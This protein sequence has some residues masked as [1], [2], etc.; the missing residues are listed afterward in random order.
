MRFV[1]PELTRLPLPGGEW[2][3]VK[4]RLTAGE[5]REMVRRYTFTKD[6]DTLHID[7]LLVGRA[8]VLAYL[9][10]WSLVGLD[11]QPL[12]IRGESLD[13]VSAA[14]DQLEPAD[15]E[16]LKDAILAHEV[17]MQQERD[18]EKKVPPGGPV[19]P[20]IS[21]SLVGVGGGMSGSGI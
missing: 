10:D 7:L 15:F 5:H 13:V 19:S 12:P 11:N 4:K 2:I 18:Q 16:I 17:A 21:P 1:R 8:K 14:I 6:D 20:P 9:V 3:A